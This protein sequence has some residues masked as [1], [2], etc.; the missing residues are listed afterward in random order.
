MDS[1]M[2]WMGEWILM[3]LAVLI[4]GL[5]GLGVVVVIPYGLYSWLTYTPPQTFELRVD[6]WT[7]TKSHERDRE[8]CTKGCRWVREVVCDQWSRQ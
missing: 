2:Q 3:P 8:I 5:I 6:S 7:C 1:I 4:I